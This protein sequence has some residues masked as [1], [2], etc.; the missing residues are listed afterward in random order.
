MKRNVIELPDLKSSFLSVEKDTI[1]QSIS[2]ALWVIIAQ[3]IKIRVVIAVL[4]KHSNP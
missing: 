4:K 2:K 3:N 1:Q